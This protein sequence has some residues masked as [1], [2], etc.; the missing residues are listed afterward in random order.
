MMIQE[1]IA[2]HAKTR[3]QFKR[4]KLRW[5]VSRGSR[6]NL[7]RIPFKSLGLKDVAACSD[8][9]IQENRRFYRDQEGML[10]TAQRARKGRRVKAIHAKIKNRRVNGHQN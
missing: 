2:V 6:R 1:V 10:A 5:R 3:S 7:G 9:E 8:G 4:N